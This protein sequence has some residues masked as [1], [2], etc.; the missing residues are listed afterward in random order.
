MFPFGPTIYMQLGAE[1]FLIF[2][3]RL[4]KQKIRVRSFLS[5]LGA[6]IRTILHN[7]LYGHPFTIQ[8]NYLSLFLIIYFKI[9]MFYLINSC[10]IIQINFL[11]ISL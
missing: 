11:R 4:I 8:L 3:L 6:G 9:D 2:T 7:P 10:I 5:L 1:L